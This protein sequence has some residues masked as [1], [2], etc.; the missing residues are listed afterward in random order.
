MNIW[1]ASTMGSNRDAIEI[2]W[3][4]PIG[5]HHS[6]QCS[7]DVSMTFKDVVQVY[8]DVAYLNWNPIGDANDT[9]T[10]VYRYLV[11]VSDVADRIDGMKGWVHFTGRSSVD[12]QERFAIWGGKSES[13]VPGDHL[14]LVLIFPSSN[15][16]QVR[17]RHQGNL[18]HQL[19]PYYRIAGDSDGV[20][21]S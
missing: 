9:V 20:C 11:D 6:S 4:L 19:Y 13:V 16:G 2:G 17:Y 8:D 10:S 18:W 1:D 5:A 21:L 15:M 7:F 14:V 3:N 12:Y